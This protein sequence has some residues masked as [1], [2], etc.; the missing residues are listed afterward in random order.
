MPGKLHQNSAQTSY[1]GGGLEGN[2]VGEV[3]VEDLDLLSGEASLLNNFVD[4]VVGSTLHNLL[5]DVGVHAG[6][7]SV[8]T[9]VGVVDIDDVRASNC[10]R[11]EK[12]LSDRLA[13]HSSL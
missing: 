9:D 8:D 5:G 12:R 11:Q 13:S 7:L 1:L 6:K 4:V 2:K 10:N 3:L